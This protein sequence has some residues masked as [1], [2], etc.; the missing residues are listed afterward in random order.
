MSA[1]IVVGGGIGGL[2]AG[3]ALAAKGWEVTVLE[4]VLSLRPAGS[5][6]LLAPNALRALG[7]ISGDL[8]AELRGLS[9]L[10]GDGGIRDARGAWLSR[11]DAG[12]ALERYGYP[13]IA[14]L[15]TALVDMLT[16]R[17]PGGALRLGTV[18]TGVDADAGTVALAS[19]EVLAGDLIVAADGVHSATR[20]ALFPGHPPAAFLGLTGW[21]AIVDAGD[22][23]PHAGTT[24]GR[25]GEFGAIPLA[26][27]R[28]YV[29]AEQ[30]AAVPMALR[31]GAEEKAELLSLYGDF[32]DPIPAII[33]RI[34]PDRIIHND[35]RSVRTPLP[36]M[37]HGTVAML[38]DAA[39]AMAP[40][41]GQGACQAIE[42]AVTLA[43]YVDSEPSVPAAVAR[44][45]AARLPRVTL[46]ARRS[47]QIAR[48]ATARRPI[49]VALRNA[50]IR[51]MGAFGPSAA[52]RQADFVMRWNH[53]AV[54]PALPA[55]SAT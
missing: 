3:L 24:W 7:M 31:S 20:R 17:L 27:G 15:R 18:V 34:A 29:F 11:N 9:A 21:Q 12:L 36:A 28:L 41:L 42:D 13:M 16:S 25:G 46:I 39:H 52:L 14:I 22:L 50:F 4:R 40:N 23:T 30:A 35:S 54:E 44:Y 38:G 33:R 53:P 19:G 48:M 43:Y 6:L 45:S 10:Q 55:P 49:A 26:D 37:H 5:A 32:H 1:A 47:E 8:V 51:L 2:T